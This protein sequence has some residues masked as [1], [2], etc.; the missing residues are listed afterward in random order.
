MKHHFPSRNRVQEFRYSSSLGSAPGFYYCCSMDLRSARLALGL[1]Q[2]KLARIS[3]V[4]RFKICTYELGDSLLSLEEQA[5][6]RKALQAE[7]D[8]FRDVSPQVE[9]GRAQPSAVQETSCG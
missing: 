5:R 3:R 4:S 6:V 7:A 1:S 8:R 9:F 2:S